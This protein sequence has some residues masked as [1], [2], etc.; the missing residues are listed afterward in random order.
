MTPNGQ[1]RLIHGEKSVSEQHMLTG[2]L[3]HQFKFKYCCEF[4][5]GNFE[6]FG[7]SKLSEKF[8][9]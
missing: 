6:A 9:K 2:N 1:N 5:E 7:K 4:I 8:Q 3:S